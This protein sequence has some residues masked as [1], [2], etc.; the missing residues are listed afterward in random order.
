V[1]SRPSRRQVTLTLCSD[2]DCSS[3][4]PTP[5]PGRQAASPLRPGQRSGVRRVFL[6]WWDSGQEKIKN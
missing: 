6:P 4:A 3:A 5:A 2:M 1:K